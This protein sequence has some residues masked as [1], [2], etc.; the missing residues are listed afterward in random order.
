MNSPSRSLRFGYGLTTLL[1]WL[2]V[3]FGVAAVVSIGV[4]IGRGGDSLLYGDPL[5]MPAEL[6]PESLKPLPANIEFTGWPHVNGAIHD[7]TTKQMLLRSLQD[8]PVAALFIAGLWL[9]R[10]F[11]R[12]VLDGDP[13]GRANVQRLRAM[14]S[15]LAVAAPLVYLLN[16]A[17]RNALFANAGPAFVHADIGVS[18]GLPLAPIV[19]GIGVFILAEVFAHG[20]DLREDVEATV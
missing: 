7:P 5:Q 3:A 15:L 6:N 9:L 12:S 2:S 8:V 16:H 13:F 4:G 19:A 20:A 14:G 17:L 11:L 10:G 18:F 1:L